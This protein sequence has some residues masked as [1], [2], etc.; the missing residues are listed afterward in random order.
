[1]LDEPYDIISHTYTQTYIYI[2]IKLI[3]EL[4]SSF[5]EPSGIKADLWI[6]HDWNRTLI[7]SIRTVATK[8]FPKFNKRILKKTIIII[9]SHNAG[10][11]ALEFPPNLNMH[12]KLRKTKTNPQSLL[13]QK[14]E[15]Q[16]RTVKKKKE[17]KNEI[18][19]YP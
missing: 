11:F 15:K 9:C 10:E 4:G 14:Q 2:Y 19:G 3:Y 12:H 6:I 1:M 13:S 16:F 7:I 5:Q 17:L 8:L 18:Y